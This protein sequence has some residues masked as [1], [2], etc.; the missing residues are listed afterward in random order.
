VNFAPTLRGFYK[1]AAEVGLDLEPFQRKIVRAA[2]G[3]QRETLILVA[4]G[5]GKSRLVGCLA[6]FHLLTHPRPSAYVCASSRDQA[7][8]VFAYARDFARHPS[9]A[10]RITVRH[11][12]LRVA[13][14]GLRVLASDA[15]KLHGLDPSWVCLDE[16]HAFR[17]DEVYRAMRTAC[18]KRA[19]SRMV[20]ISTAGIG[21]ESPLGAL[22]ARALAQPKV[23]RSG[24][25]TDAEGPSL[26]MLEWAVPEN[27]DASIPAI[28]K[29]ANPASWISEQALAEQRD[30]VPRI[31]YERF[32]LNRWR[33]HEGSWLPPGSYQACV[34]EPEFTPGESVWVGVDVGGQRSDTAVVWVS[35]RL[36]V[37]CAIFEGD[38]GVLEA[39]EE[40]RELAN[41]Y[42]VEELIFD[43]FRFTQAALELEREGLRVV[44]FAQSDSRMCPASDRL[45]RAIVEGRVVLPPDPRLRRHAANA[46]QRHTRRGW[47]IDKERSANIDGIVALA[48]AISRA[49]TRPAPATLL[50]WI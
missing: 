24:C 46:I 18:I 36:H 23:T 13:N 32:H 3:P 40:V 33:A 15:P 43:P 49:E 29:G 27:A 14:G 9:V 11:L 10:E 17:D 30:A 38:Q 28:A 31:A 42:A 19:D 16:L 25:F 21:H 4:R 41:T 2:F 47:R 8:V 48:M 7:S 35:E 37:G 12:E 34:G 6:V 44:Q 39:A 26:R 5:N 22:R 50:G 1:F 20:V 45:Y